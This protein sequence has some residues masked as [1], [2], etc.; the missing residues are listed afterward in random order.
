MKKIQ[1]RA[2][3]GSSDPA[4][5]LRGRGQGEGG[6][7]GEG[8]GRRDPL[9]RGHGRGG[10]KGEGEGSGGGGTDSGGGGRAGVTVNLEAYGHPHI[11]H[12]G[13]RHP[14][15]SGGHPPLIESFSV[16]LSPSLPPLPSLLW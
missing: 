13:S 15:R 5:A 12:R 7:K 11:H 14:I 6:V 8:E 3:A 9:G 1:R 16:L 10:V 2:A 4:A